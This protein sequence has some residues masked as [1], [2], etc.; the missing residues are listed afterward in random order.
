MTIEETEKLFKDEMNRILRCPKLINETSRADLFNK[1]LL[2]KIIIDKV[3]RNSN[4]EE[5]LSSLL[6]RRRLRHIGKSKIIKQEDGKYK[7]TSD[8]GEN[9]FFDARELFVDKKYPNYIEPY[10]CFN[11][12]HLYILKTE[13]EAK[14][15]SGISFVGKPFLHSVVLIGDYIVDFNYDLVM[16]KYLYCQLTSFEVLE[17]LSS[18]KLLEYKD[19]LIENRNLLNM[20]AYLLNFA[21]DEVIENLKIKIE[22]K[23]KVGL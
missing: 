21:F 3:I 12:S 17:E 2:Y 6:S 18:E 1:H 14:V 22:N 19:M 13:K 15:L 5:F 23:N 11:N 20:P 4:R 8:F 7:L 10:Y 16:S 9:V